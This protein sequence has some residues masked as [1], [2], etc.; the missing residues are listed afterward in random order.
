[1]ANAER[2]EAEL[3]GYEEV[4]VVSTVASG[5]FRARISCRR[6]VYQLRVD[7]QRAAGDGDSVPYP[8]SAAKCER[9]HRYLALPDGHESRS[10]RSWGPVSALQRGP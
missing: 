7:V 8:Y 4:P 9:Q 3:T 5:E 1:M 2:I 10:Y 6:A